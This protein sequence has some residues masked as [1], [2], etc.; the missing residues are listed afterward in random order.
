MLEKIY[1]WLKLSGIQALHAS[2]YKSSFLTQ[3]QN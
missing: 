3:A 1:E 2:I